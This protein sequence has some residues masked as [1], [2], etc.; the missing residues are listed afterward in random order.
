MARYCAGI[1]KISVEVHERIVAFMDFESMFNWRLVNQYLYGLVVDTYDGELMKA[2]S[3]HVPDP[4]AFLRLMNKYDVVLIGDSAVSILLRDPTIRPDTLLVA[5]GA[6]DHG[7]FERA[8]SQGGFTVTNAPIPYGRRGMRYEKIGMAPGCRRLNIL[9]APSAGLLE[10]LAVAPHTAWMSFV[11]PTAVGCGYAPLTFVRRT[12]VEPGYPREALLPSLRRNNFDIAYE[13]SQW[14]E[15]NQP[16]HGSRSRLACPAEWF[17]CP[18][19]AR[20]WVDGG[21]YVTSVDPCRRVTTAFREAPQRTLIF[22]G[23]QWDSELRQCNGPCHPED[24]MHNTA[25]LTIGESDFK[26][27]ILEENVGADGR[28]FFTVEDLE[29]LVSSPAQAGFRPGKPYAEYSRKFRDI[30][31]VLTRTGYI[32][33]DGRKFFFMQGLPEDLRAETSTFPKS[34]GSPCSSSSQD[35]GSLYATALPTWP[36]KSLNATHPDP[37][38]L[39]AILTH[40]PE[41]VAGVTIE[42]FNLDQRIQA[43]Q[44]ELYALKRDRGQELGRCVSQKAAEGASA[45]TARIQA[46]SRTDDEARQHDDSSATEGIIHEATQPSK[47]TLSPN[48]SVPWTADSLAPISEQPTTTMSAPHAAA[49]PHILLARPLRYPM[50]STLP[51]SALSQMTVKLYS[52]TPCASYRT[53]FK[54]TREKRTTAPVQLRLM[55]ATS[56]APS[57]L[58][59]EPTSLSLS[60]H[61][62]HSTS[63]SRKEASARTPGRPSLC[64]PTDRHVGQVRLQHPFARNP[65][66]RHVPQRIAAA[67]RIR[68]VGDL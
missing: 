39:T 4:P 54:R 2:I 67:R 56:S 55:S 49:L 26:R 27:T 61:P 12:L 41:I 30:R 48:D 33:E 44:E 64:V 47:V 18:R 6:H 8:L 23:W 7:D 50:I 62:S 17:V 25:I 13:P 40:Q 28:H 14:P 51:L 68:R 15:Y 31:A 59:R 45:R 43:I 19:Q 22:D 32:G 58:T 1:Y 46:Y 52:S 37:A 36:P 63:T 35:D 20:S 38:Y 57:P 66:E 53:W 29:G 5:V 34:W 16:S 9:I 60:P 42:A 11:G 65:N 24:G 10:V 3:P 21:A